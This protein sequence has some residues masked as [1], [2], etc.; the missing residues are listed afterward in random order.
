[1]QMSIGRR[2]F[3]LF[4]CNFCMN[5]IKF[6]RRMIQ[7]GRKSSAEKFENTPKPFAQPAATQ[8]IVSMAGP[9]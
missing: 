2:Q 7:I 3:F 9:A 6:T 4:L 5:E 8:Y 1:M